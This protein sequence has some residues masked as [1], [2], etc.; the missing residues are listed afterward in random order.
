M[1]SLTLCLDVKAFGDP[2][3]CIA[4]AGTDQLLCEKNQVDLAARPSGHPEVHG[5][6]SQSIFQE[7]QGVLIT[8]PENPFTS[9]IGIQP[10]N[11]YKFTWTI[12]SSHCK[13]VSYDD[14][15]IE[16]EI[17]PEISLPKATTIHSCGYDNVILE[18]ELP[19]GLMGDWNSN[20]TE[21]K[22]KFPDN[23]R[24][25]VSALKEGLSTFVWQVSSDACK[26]I[27][28]DTFHVLHESI[29]ELLEIDFQ[30]GTNESLKFNI[31]VKGKTLNSNWII[32]IVEQPA[33]GSITSLDAYEFEYSPLLNFS[34][35]DQIIYQLCY[36][37]CPS[38]CSE[39]I[40][41][42]RIDDNPFC[43]PPAIITP[44]DDGINDYF[45]INCESI[46]E[47]PELLI[48][49]GKGNQ[50]Y[51]ANRYKNDFNG[52]IENSE[53]PAGTYFYI[54]RLTNPN[55]EILQGF[56]MIHR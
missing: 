46:D 13:I 9:V 2:E 4:N 49:D 10:G 48:F 51:Q 3:Y 26:N 16:S 22:I 11:S 31:P 21:S 8:E 25:E 18:A 45:E 47:E 35:Y 17:S 39:G 53:L 36:S 24:T 14:V 27:T 20:C 44:T 6:W 50:V 15:V 55:I 32:S 12:T 28:A 29:P 56:L 23:N 37:A 19:F 34:G 54:I 1:F 7:Q 41:N 52:S 43:E 40:V 38:Q 42:F 30:T 5:I 33:F